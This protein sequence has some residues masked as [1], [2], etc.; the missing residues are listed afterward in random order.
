MTGART[1]AGDRREVADEMKHLFIINPNAGKKTATA[2]LEA[3]IRGLD[4][5]WEILRTA[6]PGD[7]RRFARAAAESGDAV[8]IYACGGD[9][10]LNEVLNGAAGFRNA[11]VTNVPLGTGNDW[12]KIFG[13]ENRGRFLDVAALANGPQTAMDLMECGGLLGVGI[14]CA[15]VDARIAADV[16]KY[17]RLPLLSGKG[18]YVL[19]LVVNVLFKGIARPMSID[20]ENAHYDGKFTLACVC[21]GRYY[22]GGFMPVGDNMPDDGVLETLVVPKVSRFTFFRLVSKYA[23]GRYHELPHLVFPHRGQ[24][25]ELKSGDDRELVAVVDGEVLRDRS[26]TIRLSDKKLNFFYP[27]GLSYAGENG[28][29]TKAL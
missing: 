27:E 15:G 14:T 24:Q 9:G 3:Q 10:T 2:R 28:A 20:V 6:Q 26:F 22:G 11:A 1:A 8:R 4:E 13:P 7:A 19:A 29:R 18:A 17:K 5:P 21:N 12:L 23:S 25:V 16:D